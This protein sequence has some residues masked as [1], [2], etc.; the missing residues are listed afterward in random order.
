MGRLDG[1]EYGHALSGVG[2]NYIWKKRAWR[3]YRA[4]AEGREVP[5]GEFGLTTKKA[6]TTFD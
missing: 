3:A 6:E 1:F 4:R 2:Q 5:W